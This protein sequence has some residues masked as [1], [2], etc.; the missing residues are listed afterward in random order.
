MKVIKL[1]SAQI[2]TVRLHILTKQ[3]GKCAVCHRVIQQNN[4]CLDHDHVTGRI[5]G[6][7]CRVC[8]RAEGKIQGIT[9]VVKNIMDGDE[10]LSNII[11]YRKWHRENPSSA[12]HPTHK[13]AEEKKELRKVRA[14]RE[15]LKKKQG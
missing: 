11:Q 3:G 6:V 10:Y 12:I 13:S 15:R 9:T 1:T 14:K 7:L 5:R 2:A 8:N 4:A